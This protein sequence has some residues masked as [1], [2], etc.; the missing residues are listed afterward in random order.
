MISVL[1]GFLFVCFCGFL[2]RKSR[3]VRLLCMKSTIQ[4]NIAQNVCD[5]CVFYFFVVTKLLGNEPYTVGKP[6]CFPFKWSHICKEHKI[7]IRYLI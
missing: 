6:V 7:L 3:C 2:Q 4:I 5:M 1:Q